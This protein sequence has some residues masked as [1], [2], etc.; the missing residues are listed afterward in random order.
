MHM[1]NL[2]NIAFYYTYI[3]SSYHYYWNSYLRGVEV[4]SRF[5]LNSRASLFAR[6]AADFADQRRSRLGVVSVWGMLSSELGTTSSSRHVTLLLTSGSAWTWGVV[7]IIIA[8]G[9][10]RKIPHKPCTT[11]YSHDTHMI[12]YLVAWFTEGH[13]FT[14]RR[15]ARVSVWHPRLRW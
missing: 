4:R 1:H 8:H 7:D 9:A 13:G 12:N 14:F 3:H 6:G 10:H 2:L 11:W 5:L 15:I